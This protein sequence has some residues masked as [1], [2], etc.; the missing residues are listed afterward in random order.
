MCESNNHVCLICFRVCV[1]VSVGNHVTNNQDIG[2][3][4]VVEP[5]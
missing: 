4:G 1:C 5:R 2:S 3:G